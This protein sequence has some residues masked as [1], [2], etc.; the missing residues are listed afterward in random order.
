MIAPTMRRIQ[1]RGL[2]FLL[3]AMWLLT[4]TPSTVAADKGNRSTD[5][6]IQAAEKLSQSFRS[7]AE[8]VRPCVVGINVTRWP[9]PEM[10]PLPQPDSLADMLREFFGEE[11][12]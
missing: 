11:Y 4:L 8:A 10:R 12:F 1:K 9:T 3:L 2:L 7:I 6:A 5:E